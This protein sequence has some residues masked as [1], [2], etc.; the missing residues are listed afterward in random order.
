MSTA[1]LTGQVTG[2]ALSGIG[3]DDDEHGQT[4][5]IVVIGYNKPIEVSAN[6]SLI[7]SAPELLDMLYTILPYIKEAT[8]FDDFYKPGAAAEIVQQIQTLLAKADLQ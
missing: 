5:A 8:E 4:V 3:I 1:L 6:A 2:Q 7:A